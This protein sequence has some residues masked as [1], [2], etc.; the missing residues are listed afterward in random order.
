MENP[1]TRQNRHKLILPLFA[2]SAFC[3][4]AA[5]GKALWEGRETDAALYGGSLVLTAAAALVHRST[6]RP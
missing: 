6:P 1:F 2:A 3:M 4:A 5:G